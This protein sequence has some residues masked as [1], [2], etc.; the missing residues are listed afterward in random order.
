MNREVHQWIASTAKTSLRF[1]RRIADSVNY[2]MPRRYPVGRYELTLPPRHRLDLFQRRWRHYDKAIQQISSVIWSK[3]PGFS[4][5]DIGGNIGDTAA[6]ICIEHDIS[7]L[8]VEGSPFFLPYLKKNAAIIGPHIKIAP[9]FIGSV[10]TNA[11]L[12]EPKGGTLSLASLSGD[13]NVSIKT[14]SDLMRDYP[15]FA[16]PK[17]IKSDTDG[18]DFEILRSSM[19]EIEIKTPVLYFEYATNFRTNSDLE[20]IHT[21]VDLVSC[22]YNRFVV[23]DNFGNLMCVVKDFARSRFEEFNHYLW[24]NRYYGQAV[25]YLDVC[26]FHNKDID[27]CE[28][29]VSK[30]MNR[31]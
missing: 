5:I 12:T 6:A 28:A 17:L 30:E 10:A 9:V 8:C 29:L 20:S 13:E 18:M 22:G 31:S 11:V 2:R 27:I 4:A 19:K 15:D 1:A 3:Y 25:Y 7:V 16:F 26:A 23:Y 24:S 14:L 21:I